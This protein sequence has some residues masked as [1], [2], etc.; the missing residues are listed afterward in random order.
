VLSLLIF[1]IAFL[2]HVVSWRFRVPRPATGV[3]LGLFFFVLFIG[4]L[5]VHSLLNLSLGFWHLFQ[6]GL[7]HTA[8]SLAYIIVYSGIEETSPTIAI[9]RAVHRTGA[10]GCFRQDLESVVNNEKFLEPRLKKLELSGLIVEVAGR[11]VLTDKGYK[12][13]GMINYISGT[14]L[15]LPKGG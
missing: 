8:F 3:L 5:L 4:L 1:G 12:L 13:A 15:N 14:F 9:V 6:I 11:I 10:I 7:F 2:L